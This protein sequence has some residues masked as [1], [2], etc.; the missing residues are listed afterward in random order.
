MTAGRK[1]RFCGALRFPVASGHNRLC[2]HEA[3][4]SLSI[5]CILNEPHAC[6]QKNNLEV[7]LIS[8]LAP[9]LKGKLRFWILLTADGVHPE[10]FLL[11]AS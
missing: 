5:H 4:H 7:S 11:E 6:Y 3:L 8:Q 1:K 10:M 9:F 2:V